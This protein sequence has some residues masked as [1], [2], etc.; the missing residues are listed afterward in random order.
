[1]ITIEGFTTTKAELERKVNAENL[2]ID[3]LINLF[4]PNNDIRSNSDGNEQFYSY[5]RVADPRAEF[6]AKSFNLLET[7]LLHPP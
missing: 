1:M 3:E 7:N 4:E 2:S 6:T 5:D